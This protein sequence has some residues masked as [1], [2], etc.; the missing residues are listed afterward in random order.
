MD[1]CNIKFILP[2]FR[3]K[4]NIVKKKG[5]KKKN[6]EKVVLFEVSVDLKTNRSIKTFENMAEK[7]RKVC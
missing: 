3:N 6:N 7:Q 2:E 4:I 5:I 1:S